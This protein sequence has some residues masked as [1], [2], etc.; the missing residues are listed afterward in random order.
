MDRTVDQIARLSQSK[1]ARGI[2]TPDVPGYY[3]VEVRDVTLSQQLPKY[4]GEVVAQNS[5]DD[6]SLW[7]EGRLYAKYERV[8]TQAGRYFWCTTGHVNHEPP[9]AG[10]WREDRLTF[11]MSTAYEVFDRVVVGDTV[12]ECIRAHT[13]SELNNPPNTTYWRIVAVR[14]GIWVAQRITRQIGESPVSA[15][16]S[17]RTYNDRVVDPDIDPTAVKLT[18]SNHPLAKVAQFDPSVTRVL[19]EIRLVDAGLSALLTGAFTPTSLS[20]YVRG[21][22]DFFNRHIA[23]AIAYDVHAS[24]DN[25]NTVDSSSVVTLAG[26]VSRINAIRSALLAH[27]ASAVFHISGSTPDVPDALTDDKDLEATC[28]AAAALQNSLGLHAAS[29]TI[30]GSG[31]LLERV[32]DGAAWVWAEAPRT[33]DT[34]LD[35]V[36]GLTA[37]YNA[38]RV[39]TSMGSPHLN[40]DDQNGVEIGDMSTAEGFIQTVNAWADALE[41]HGSNKSADGS[42]NASPY[43]AFSGTARKDPGVKI[44]FRASDISSAFRL[45]E[46]L[47]RAYQRH[48]LTTNVHQ[49]VAALGAFNEVSLTNAY[50]SLAGRLTLAWLNA[51]STTSAPVPERF[52]DSA[53]ELA[54]FGWTLLA[55]PDL[56]VSVETAAK[57]AAGRLELVASPRADVVLR[58][59]ARARPAQGLRGAAIPLR[60]RRSLRARRVAAQTTQAIDWVRQTLVAGLARVAL[61]IVPARVLERPAV[62]VRI[63]HSERCCRLLATRR[64]LAAARGRALAARHGIP[65]RHRSGATAAR[66][67]ARSGRAS[68]PS[69]SACATRP[70]SARRNFARI[71]LGRAGSQQ[72]RENHGNRSHRSYP[73]FD[74]TGAGFFLF[75]SK[76]N[77]PTIC[78]P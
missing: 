31:A 24:A 72:Q 17:I 42:D 15:T 45:A 9:N 20:T 34:L 52:N 58:G 39:R 33:L 2:L 50:I 61:P 10:F 78:T 12:Y 3:T 56:F 71:R 25:T 1:A 47:D 53:V 70:A 76:S 5:D 13:S 51:T 69:A 18:P 41:R 32:A 75:S 36:N 19:D 59:L 63:P 27:A 4:A 60:A 22:I 16:L 68:S 54:R 21:Q 38:H 55:A 49:N 48:A 65:R 35:A 37:S 23:S 6:D 44:A 66:G 30:H 74:P 29:P 40:Q 26:A 46:S 28:I 64:F 8:R 67:S 73:H 62:S 57:R 77:A 7:D 43:H 11:A 14:T